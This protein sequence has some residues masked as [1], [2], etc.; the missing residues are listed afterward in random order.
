M[1]WISTKWNHFWFEKESSINMIMARWLLFFCG[2]VFYT[3]MKDVHPTS[4]YEQWHPLSFYKLLPG[5]LS[6]STLNTLRV[7]W[8]VFSYAAGLGILYRYTSL[9]AF[10]TGVVYLGHDYCFG[11]VYHSHHMYIMCVGILV[12]SEFICGYSKRIKTSLDLMST[13]Y[14]WPL[15][16]ARCYVVYMMFVCGVEKL[17]YGGGLTW[18]FSE[19]FFL[20]LWTNPYQPPLN[21]WITSQPLFVSQAFAAVALFV[22]ELGAPLVFLGKKSRIFFF[23]IW[24]FFHFFVS[25]TYGNHF[26]FYSQILCYALFIDWSSFLPKQ[27]FFYKDSEGYT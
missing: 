18:A 25:L 23:F 15:Q 21:Q 9:V 3:F 6:P 14:H 20:R 16:W 10:L 24:S 2:A 5:P 26:T 8:L 4:F 22:V 12:V 19:S 11:I 13:D 17:W 27:M 1:N 7:I